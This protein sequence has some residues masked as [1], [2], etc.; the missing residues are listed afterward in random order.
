MFQDGCGNIQ[1]PCQVLF[2]DDID[3]RWS[4]RFNIYVN[5]RIFRSNSRQRDLCRQHHFF[6]NLEFG[7]SK[8]RVV[9]CDL[10][11]VVRVHC[12]VKL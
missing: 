9:G 12:H 8:R 6:K 5:D 4:K 2:C 1:P 7:A 3:I 11:E 10:Y